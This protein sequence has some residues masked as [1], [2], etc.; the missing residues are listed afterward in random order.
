M[1]QQSDS[2][3]LREAA[4]AI[5]TASRVAV[6]THVSP[7]PDAIGSL[8]GLTHALRS[9]G[10]QTLPLCDDPVPHGLEFLAGTADVRNALPQD[11]VPDL[12]I[13]VD[14]SD[15]ERL[16]NVWISLTEL[17]VPSLVIDHHITNLNFGTVNVVNSLWA[18]TA[19]GLLLLLDALGVSITPET[20][21]CLLT[22]IVGDTRSFST[23]STTPFSLQVAAR[24]MDA[25]ADIADITERVFSRRSVETLRFWGAGLSKLQLE[26]GVIWTVVTMEDC[27]ALGI[28]E[29]SVGSGL[30]NLLITADEAVI[31]AVFAEQPDDTVEASF[32]A[33]PGYD[34]AAVAL[35]L[36]GGGH[37]LAAG[38]R[39]SGKLPETIPSVVGLLKQAAV[40]SRA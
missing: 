24:L 23:A 11:F 3:A 33:R 7:D 14:G 40:A 13:G 35:A 38:T 30:S 19:E 28:N 12:A 8:L 6:V 22:G 16:G 20:A 39:L 34:V 18:S 26:S 36:G 2:S 27:Q 15:P 5:Q 21:T 17:Q 25:G 29:A 32:R 9:L 10:K 31:S 4:A 37:S 1:T